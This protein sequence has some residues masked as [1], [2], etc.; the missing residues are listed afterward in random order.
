M[1]ALFIGIYS[2]DIDGGVGSINNILDYG[3]I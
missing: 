1:A 2:W 3:W